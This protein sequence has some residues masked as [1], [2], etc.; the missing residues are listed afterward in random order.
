[1]SA[2]IFTWL[3]DWN[4]EEV[5]KPRNFSIQF[6]DGYVER[7]ANGLNTDLPQ[8]NAN[9]TARSSTDNTAIMAFLQTTCQAGVI[10]FQ[11]QPYADATASL[12]TCNDFKAK[13]VA[14]GY[15]DITCVFQQVVA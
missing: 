6:G 13:P 14:G 12:W 4:S 5:H 11:F 15:Y 3:E 9:F 8:Y 1:M 10:A 7:A 2:P